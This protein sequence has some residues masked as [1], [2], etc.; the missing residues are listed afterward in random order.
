MQREM[1]EKRILSPIKSKENIGRIGS[2]VTG[3]IILYCSHFGF[4]PTVLHQY[5]QITSITA[6]CPIWRL[7][8]PPKH[9]STVI[10]CMLAC[11]VSVLCVHTVVRFYISNECSPDVSHLPLA[12]SVLNM[13]DCNMLT[14]C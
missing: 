9:R 5:L 4:K 10:E 6:Y 12:F 1:N 3:F 2:R 7:Q 8:R 13:C 11:T 14:S